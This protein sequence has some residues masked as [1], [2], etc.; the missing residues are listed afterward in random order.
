MPAYVQGMRGRAT[1][2]SKSVKLP[3]EISACLAN[4][5]E[6]VNTWQAASR[7]TLVARECVRVC[8]GLKVVLFVIFAISL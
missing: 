6:N 5:D 1:S 7:S 2:G 3:G 8:V 4:A